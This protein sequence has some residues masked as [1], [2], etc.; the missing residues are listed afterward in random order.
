MNGCLK[1]P[2]FCGNGLLN[3]QH[4]GYNDKKHPQVQKGDRKMAKAP[5]EGPHGVDRWTS[6]GYGLIVNGVKITPENDEND[7]Q[8]KGSAGNR[9][10][11]NEMHITYTEEKHFTQEQVQAL[12]RSVR[13]ISAE[14]P[15][16]LHKALMHS[17]TVLTAWDG[18]KLVGLA[19]VLD[20]GELVA[21]IHYVLVD[22]AYQG[23]GIAT[24]MITRI[25]E[26]YRDYLYLEVMPDERQNAVFYERL[27]FQILPEGTAMQI[28]NFSDKR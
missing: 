5:E 3:A 18:E 22:P 10:R 23:R 2:F 8:G 9:L 12:F 13:W 6:N 27:G 14:Y 28:A 11:E 20:D 4:F 17:Q 19:R 24:A 7:E 26:K 15:S 16:R 21:F 25:R 1:Q